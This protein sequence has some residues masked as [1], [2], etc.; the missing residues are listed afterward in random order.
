MFNSTTKKQNRLIL[1]ALVV[2]LAAAA[3]LIAVT[4]SANKKNA[5]TNPPLDDSAAET[6]AVETGNPSRETKTPEE[7]E[8][9]KMIPETGSEQESKAPVD[10]EPKDAAETNTKDAQVSAIQSPADAL[11]T[12]SAPLDGV[13]LKKHSLDVP[14]FSMT[15]N[16]Y[17]T[18]TGLDFAASPGTAVC[19]AADGV[20]CEITNDPMMGVTVGVQHSGGAVTKYK[21]LSEDSLSMNEVGKAVKRGQVIGSAGETALIESAEEAHVHFELLVNGE[22]KNPADYMKVTYLSDLTED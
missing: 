16:D 6:P 7:T 21:G 10:S 15:M 17:R 18:H 19:S 13:V 8:A 20:I 14:V 22:A 9:A 12:F 5:E 3:V 11:P 2:L 4:G 1:S